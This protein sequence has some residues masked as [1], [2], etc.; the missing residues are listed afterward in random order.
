M[1]ETPEII[2]TAAATDAIAAAPKLTDEQLAKLLAAKDTPDA[3][4]TTD[5][6]SEG[7]AESPTIH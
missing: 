7:E 6:D 5:E 1:N 2:T 4:I 3:F